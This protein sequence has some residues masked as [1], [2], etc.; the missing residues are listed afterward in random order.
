MDEVSIDQ[1]LNTH[2]L[3]SE[4]VITHDGPEEFPHFFPSIKRETALWIDEQ[5]D[6]EDAVSIA[7]LTVQKEDIALQLSK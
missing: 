4:D 5:L 3:S 2:G 7:F 6:W 1:I